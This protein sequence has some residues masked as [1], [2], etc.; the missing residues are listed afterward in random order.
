MPK[1][2]RRRMLS[3]FV[4]AKRESRSQNSSPCSGSGSRLARGRAEERWFAL[5]IVVMDGYT[6]AMKRIPAA[7]RLQAA[8]ARIDDPE[9]EGARACLTIYRDAAR[10]AAEAADARTRTHVSLGPLDG[11]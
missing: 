8:L 4:P 2:W 9:G 7:E 11:A 6:D 10:A 5:R 3:P 1:L